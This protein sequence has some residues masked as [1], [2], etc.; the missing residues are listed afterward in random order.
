[1]GDD[2]AP[3][4]L[5]WRKHLALTLYLARSPGRVR[6]RD[7]LVA[8]LWGEK[9]E[10]A[11]RHSLNE[12]L[13]ILRRCCGDE[14]VDA[15]AGQVR[16]AAEAVR[17]DIDDLDTLIGADS[18]A[19]AALVTGEF[20]EGFGVADAWEFENWLAVERSHWKE[21][22]VTALLT[23]A[24]QRLAAGGAAEVRTIAQRALRLDPTSDEACRIGMRA[25][26]LAGDRGAALDL[27]AA[28]ARRLEEDFEMQ[29]EPGTVGL[30]ERIR[31]ERAWRVQPPADSHAAGRR[32]PLLGRESEL[33]ALLEAWDACTADRSSRF[34]LIE[35][36]SGT[37]KTRLLDE[38]VARA[39]L[40]GAATAVIR[41]VEAEAGDPWSGAI[42]LVQALPPAEPHGERADVSPLR[43]LTGVLASVTVSTPTL[44]AF[45]DAQWLD[46]ETLLALGAMLRDLADRPLL[47]LLCTT[48][49]PR[50]AELDELRARVGRDL[51]GVIVSIGPLRRDALLELA[52]AA[53]PSYD[54]IELDRLTRRLTTDT[55]GLP[56]LAVELLHAVATGL[57]LGEVQGAWPEPM[58]TLDHTL[59]TALPDAITA[60]IRTGFRRLSPTARTV[61]AAASVLGPRV[62]PGL[63]ARA[64]GFERADVDEALDELEWSRWLEAD[65][66][67]YTF[68]AAISRAIVARDMT[69][70]GQRQRFTAGAQSR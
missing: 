35:G 20:L 17:L 50:R 56:L 59:P 30:V 3:P 24:E 41:S 2:P 63:L 39:R 45:D 14:H 18:A 32:G 46:R 16:L 44:I 58:R 42:G 12:A 34:A 11:A 33:G 37:G 54:A 48:P 13:R 62:E 1:M 49:L 4:E 67:G 38:V 53:L 28:F 57:D 9:P 40:D 27:F 69:T 26:G 51:A 61:L 65:P 36:E 25:A 68:V 43:A 19:A 52:R 64:T 23:H 15:S 31:R 66:R 7:H 47:V 70:P 29:P 21:R 8:L 22:G 10:S 60:A 5:L 55:A 6:T